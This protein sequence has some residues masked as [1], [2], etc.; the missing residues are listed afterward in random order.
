[1]SQN[2]N[3]AK[4]IQLPIAMYGKSGV[5]KTSIISALWNETKQLLY[6]SALKI[7]PYDDNTLAGLHENLDRL[8]GS[9]YA[10]T[11]NHKALPGN[12]DEYHYALMLTTSGNSSGVQ[13]WTGFSREV[14]EAGEPTLLFGFKDYPGGWSDPRERSKSTTY[15]EKWEQY[16]QWITAS[17]V[18]IVPVDATLL[19]EAKTDEQKARV[20][21]LLG[22]ATL[23]EEVLDRWVKARVASELP[24]LLVFAPLR[25]E[26]YF[27]DNGGS[28]D[29]SEELLSQFYRLYS[30]H[31][32]LVT[33]EDALKRIQ[34]EY[35]PIDTVGAVQV[36]NA[37]WPDDHEPAIKVPEF[38]YQVRSPARYSPYGGIELLSALCRHMLKYWKAQQTL[39]TK[40]YWDKKQK[41][42]LFDGVLSIIFDKSEREEA[43][44]LLSGWV[45]E[46][47]AFQ[48]TLNTLAARPQGR[49]VVVLKKAGDS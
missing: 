26:T 1:M 5:G 4:G 47:P 49:R 15:K 41:Q 36:T 7:S 19:M 38:R 39:M 2:G 46:F 35:H 6:D 42:G 30:E 11:F 18:L 31:V 20:P 9:F 29:R 8:Q 27:A 3:Q 48:D 22:F 40:A 17:S 28:S 23:K 16:L 45:V 34:I 33:K 14:F 12:T 13:A 10:G 44:Q 43:R 25:C 24:G 37:S 21:T 32:A